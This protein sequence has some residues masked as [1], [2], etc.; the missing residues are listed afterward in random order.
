MQPIQRASVPSGAVSSVSVLIAYDT[1][2]CPMAWSTLT[3]M[4]RSG[5]YKVAIAQKLKRNL[6]G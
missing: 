1:A 5:L 3:S 2:D 4:K 6:R